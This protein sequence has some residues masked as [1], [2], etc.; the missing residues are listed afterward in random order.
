MHALETL[1]QPC[2]GS[3]CSNAPVQ[4]LKA[5][6]AGVV[7][8]DLMDR[9]LQQLPR[10]VCAGTTAGAWVSGGSGVGGGAVSNGPEAASAPK[11]AHNV[12]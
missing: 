9:A 11:H 5:E 6:A 7:V 4:L 2:S 3:R 12:K 8:V 1:Q 10:V